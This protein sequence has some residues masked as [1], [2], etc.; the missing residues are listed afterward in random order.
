MGRPLKIIDNEV[1]FSPLTFTGV[2]MV[3][4]RTLRKLAAACMRIEE[5]P[6]EAQDC[7][8]PVQ[9]AKTFR[10]S[11]DNGVEQVG[12]SAL[13]C[14]ASSAAGWALQSCSGAHP[15]M[16]VTADFLAM[17]LLGCMWPPGRSMRGSTLRH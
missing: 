17:T 11:L 4:S 12:I 14:D 5:K 15:G 13:T 6:A 3:Y 7:F 9:V 10:A 1:R 2:C 16:Q 8:M